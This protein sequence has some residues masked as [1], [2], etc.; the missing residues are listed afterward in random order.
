MLR[1]RALRLE[2]LP[3]RGPATFTVHFDSSNRGCGSFEGRHSWWVEERRRKCPKDCSKT[4]LLC[5]ASSLS[6]VLV[7]NT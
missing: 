7:T 6:Q 2:P 5:Q 1:L 4:Q 3:H